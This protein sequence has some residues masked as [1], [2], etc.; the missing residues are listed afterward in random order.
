[1]RYSDWEHRASGSRRHSRPIT[2]SS[3]S[4][5]APK[6]SVTEPRRVPSSVA[7]EQ[8]GEN[9][10]ELPLPDN[11]GSQTIRGAQPSIPGW[12]FQ[13]APQVQ[14]SPELFVGTENFGG[15]S[16]YLSPYLLAPYRSY[17]GL[18]P[19]FVPQD[20]YFPNTS[21]PYSGHAGYM[22]G[23]SSILNNLSPGF[24]PYGAYPLMPNVG[25][26]NRSRLGG[27]AEV[28]ETGPSPASGNYFQPA[29][30][31]PSASG[32]YYAGGTPWQ[33]PINIPSTTKDY[34]GPSGTPFNK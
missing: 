30:S 32:N 7:A 21:N 17:Q 2:D 22:G 9:H 23:A 24:R 10:Q 4:T 20:T 3:S 8:S 1:L 28:I 18:N 5:T 15:S 13:P 27:A 33:V 6:D 19:G 14:R 29:A 25:G 11:P 16:A 12:A 31:D 26:M 34:W